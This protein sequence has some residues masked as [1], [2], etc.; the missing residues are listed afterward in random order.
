MLPTFVDEYKCIVIRFMAR[1]VDSGP[2]QAMCVSEPGRLILDQ[3]SV[4]FPKFSWL[5]KTCKY[6]LGSDN[7]NWRKLLR[8]SK[9]LE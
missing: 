7:E 8:V 1:A 6:S 3:L 4:H 9:S 2:C 5:V